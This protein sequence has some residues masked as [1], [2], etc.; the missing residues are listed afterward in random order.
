MQHTRRPIM[1]D[2][3]LAATI[4][5]AM[6]FGSMAMADDAKK[7]PPRETPPSALDE[8]LGLEEEEREAGRSAE[9]SAKQAAEQELRRR[10]TQEEINSALAEAVSQMELS[11]ERL[12][13]ALDS[14]LGTQRIQ[15]DVLAKLDQLINQA[16]RQQ[17]RSQSSSSS[18][19]QQQQ[20]Q[21]Q[22]APGRRQQQQQQEGEERG[23]QP[24]EGDPPPLQEGDINTVLEESRSE[25]GSLPERVREMLLQGRRERFSSLYEQ[26]TREYYRRLAED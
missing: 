3:T 2:A 25:W 10:L 24:Q 7:E 15:E 1:H 22:Q 13:S 26:L 8:L 19:Q 14:G 11:A 18:A 21:P 16:R 12:E 9:E 23:G 5:V 17:S 4:S 6:F 20:Q